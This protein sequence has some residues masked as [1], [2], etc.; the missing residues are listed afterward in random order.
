MSVD[1]QVVSIYIYIFTKN[2]CFKI[3]Y[4]EYIPYKLKD[5]FHD[6]SFQHEIILNKLHIN[7]KRKK[8]ICQVNVPEKKAN[9]S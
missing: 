3:I 7:R 5:S 4:L 9:Q 8:T 2:D 1:H 6:Y